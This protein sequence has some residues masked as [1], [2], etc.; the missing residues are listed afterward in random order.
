MVPSGGLPVAAHWHHGTNDV[1][2]SLRAHSSGGRAVAPVGGSVAGKEWAAQAQADLSFTL[3]LQLP[4]PGVDSEPQAA[5]GPGPSLRGSVVITREEVQGWRADQVRLWAVQ[6]VG[7]GEDDASKVGRYRGS[8][9]LKLTP[10]SVAK[11]SLGLSPT[12]VAAV[13]AALTKGQWGTW[14]SPR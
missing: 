14:P 2:G 1:A 4:G 13:L 5:L 12:A 10:E 9:L 8:M 7:M 11:P 6:V 3:P